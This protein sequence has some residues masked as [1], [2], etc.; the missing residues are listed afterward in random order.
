MSNLGIMM[1]RLITVLY[2]ITVFPGYSQGKIK[3]NQT[4]E[5]I[6]KQADTLIRAQILTEKSSLK[7]K[8]DLEYFWYQAGIIKSNIGGYSGR[9][10]HGSYAVFI[11]ENLVCKGVFNYGLKDGKWKTWF[12]NG[13]L[14]IISNWNKG[15]RQGEFINYNR[16]GEILEKKNYFHGLLHGEQIVR[17]NDS[18]FIKKFRKGKEIIPGTLKEKNFTSEPSDSILIHESEKSQG[19]YNDS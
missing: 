16:Q 1:I 5:I 13:D 18:L 2:L 14:A 15:K 11:N 6:I 10:L 19:G 4:R 7:S 12:N 3:K 8:P 17:E 9:L